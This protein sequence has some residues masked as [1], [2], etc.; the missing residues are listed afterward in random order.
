MG[1]KID[2]RAKEMADNILHFVDCMNTFLI[3]VGKSE[4]EV[5][6]ATKKIKKMVKNYKKGKEEIFRPEFYELL[7]DADFGDSEDG[8]LYEAGDMID[9]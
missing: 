6:R 1:K 9:I 2:P 5:K 3:P 7:E 4:S 8:S